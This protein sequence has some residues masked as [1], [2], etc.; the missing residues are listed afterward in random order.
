VVH[1]FIGFVQTVVD[2]F[3]TCRGW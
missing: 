3:N 2:R 1:I